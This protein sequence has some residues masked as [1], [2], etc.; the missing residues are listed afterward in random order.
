MSRLA[1]LMPAY[2]P[3]PE[4][5]STL[6]ELRVLSAAGV[7]PLT[8][9]LTDDGS[10]DRIRLESLPAASNTFDIVLL[11]HEVNLGQGAALETGRRA[12]LVGDDHDVFVTMDADGQ[13]RPDDLPGLVRPVREDAVDVVFGNRFATQSNVPFVRK[14]VLSLARVFEATITGLW[15]RDAHNGYRAFSRKGAE[16]VRIRQNR[17]A[18]ATE[19]KQRVALAKRDLKIV[20]APVTIRYSDESMARGQSSLGAV[21]IL[22]DIFFRFLF[23]PE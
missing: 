11:R 19:I 14:L 12:A 6:S 1:I 17:M 8:V 22:R 20:E 23:G 5:Q 21:D 2:N 4:M 18:H 7:G 13:H 15:L 9:Y 16:V 10:R 3:G